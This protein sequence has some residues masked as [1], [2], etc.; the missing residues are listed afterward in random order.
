MPG[1]A[2]HR[3]R[4]A[5]G[6]TDARAE[7]YTRAIDN[8]RPTWL[9]TLERECAGVTTDRTSRNVPVTYNA[10]YHPVHEAV[11]RTPAASVIDEHTRTGHGGGDTRTLATLLRPG[12]TNA[13]EDELGRTITTRRRQDPVRRF[14]SQRVVRDWPPG[15]GRRVA[16]LVHLNP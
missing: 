13:D 4:S 7:V 15:P 3:R 2:E 9:A 11:R 6:D 16:G 1:G 5:T 10:R 14:G 8:T 12:T